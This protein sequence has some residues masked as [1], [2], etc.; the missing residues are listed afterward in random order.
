MFECHF[1]RYII[2]RYIPTLIIWNNVIPAKLP[3]NKRNSMFIPQMD[4]NEQKQQQK[5]LPTTQASKDQNEIIEFE[6]EEN[7]E[8]VTLPGASFAHTQ[9]KSGDNISSSSKSNFSIPSTDI[10]QL[11]DW[12]EERTK[13]H[14]AYTGNL[15]G[16][17]SDED[18]DNN[19]NNNTKSQ[20]EY[21]DH[22]INSLD[23]EDNEEERLTDTLNRLGR[24]AIIHSVRDYD[25]DT[26]IFQ[27]ENDIPRI[28]AL[29]DEQ[30][31]WRESMKTDK[32]NTKDHDESR[33]L[34][35]D[36]NVPRET[37]LDEETKSQLKKANNAP[38]KDAVTTEY[39][40]KIDQILDDEVETKHKMQDR[41]NWRPRIALE[42][43]LLPPIDTPR[44]SWPYWFLAIAW[45][46]CL[47]TIAL[48]CYF[49]LLY[50]LHY[51]YLRSINWLQ[52]LIRSFLIS[53]CVVQPITAFIVT[54]LA[55]LCG[56]DQKISERVQVLV[57]DSE[58]NSTFLESRQ[59]Y[60]FSV[61]QSVLPYQP[62][63]GTEIFRLTI[64]A[65]RRHEIREKLLRLILCVLLLFPLIAVSYSGHNKYVRRKY[66]N[67]FK[68][69]SSF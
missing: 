34:G 16:A 60:A 15:V 43:C 68:K 8:Q 12:L 64:A 54:F 3:M 33:P 62:P 18:E 52:S 66:S 31:K 25:P 29:I 30:I 19:L 26:F 9:R 65:R 51:G 35:M 69:E 6:S 42:I 32:N 63:T 10:P 45:I 55:T 61:F 40:Q 5:P 58:N 1:L 36:G 57:E 48:M 23:T 53:A 13:Q 24:L 7:E 14:R 67:L 11:E 17:S 20:E 2:A 47:L 28:E 27:G 37:I 46:V 4:D 21:P 41:R 44:C 59:P 39:L 38:W 49:T 56:K 50:G 22:F